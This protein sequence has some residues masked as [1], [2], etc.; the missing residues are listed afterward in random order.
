MIDK[1][2]DFTN[3]L[4]RRK[5]LFQ[6]VNFPVILWSGGSISRNFPANVFPFRANSHFLYFAGIP[7]E[8]AAILLDNHQLTLFMDD[9]HPNSALWHGYSPKCSDLAN[10]I[11]ADHHFPLSELKK[12]SNNAATIA[13]LDLF[14]YNQQC[15]ILNRKILPASKSQGIDL[16]LA[17]AIVSLRLSH[18]QAAINQLK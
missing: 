6:K 12:Y 2:Q 14:T 11:G 17:Q 13:V 15:E 18:D 16:E 5:N 9:P 10:Q 4:Q 3:I 7:L 1:V 8:N